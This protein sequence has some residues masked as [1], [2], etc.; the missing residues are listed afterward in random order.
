MFGESGIGLTRKLMTIGIG[1]D[2]RV[3]EK[4]QK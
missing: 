2:N 1:L 3:K 4:L